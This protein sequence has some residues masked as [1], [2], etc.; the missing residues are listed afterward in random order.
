[1]P[2]SSSFLLALFCVQP[3]MSGISTSMG[4][5]LT[6]NWMV[7][8]CSVTSVPATGSCLMTQPSGTV[9]LKS[10]VMAMR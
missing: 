4:P 6:T 1:M 7:G 3:M 10:S 9:E 2:D 8:A 5:L